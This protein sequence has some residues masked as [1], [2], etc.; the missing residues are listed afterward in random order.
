MFMHNKSER[1]LTVLNKQLSPV[2]LEALPEPTASAVQQLCKHM[3][4][5][6][7][8]LHTSTARLKLQL[9]PLQLILLTPCNEP[10]TQTTGTYPHCRT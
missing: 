3:E 4:S 9:L 7:T 2:L 8:A 6:I 5:V 10:S 1:H